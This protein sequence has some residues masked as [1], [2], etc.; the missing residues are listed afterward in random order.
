VHLSRDDDLV[1]PIWSKVNKKQHL[2]TSPLSYTKTKSGFKNDE[3]CIESL[4]FCR[5]KWDNKMAND[6]TQL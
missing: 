5:N 2:A 3:A 1:D 6:D 4:L